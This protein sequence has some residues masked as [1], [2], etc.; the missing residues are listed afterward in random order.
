VAVGRDYIGPYRL[1][2]LI[3]A[4]KATQIW[5][6]MNPSD[7]ERVA[8]KSLQPSHLD[9]K[10]EL[11]VLRHEHTVGQNFSHPAVNRVR[12]FNV[13]RGIP[14]VVMDFF[15]APNLKQ[16]MR[17]F[18]ERIAQYRE[19]IIRQAA[20]ALQ[21]VHEKD[22]VHC[23]VKPDN[24]LLNEN[25]QLK[26]I[27]FAIAQKV[28]K[29]IGRLLSGKSAVQ[30]TRSYMAPEQIRGAS[31]DPRTDVYSLGCVLFELF[32]GKTPYTANNPDELLNKHLR[33][34]IPSLSAH[35]DDVTPE[36]A[37]L[38]SRM[39]AKK[40]EDRPQSMDAFLNELGKIS[41]TKRRPLA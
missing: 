27:D 16:S 9:N 29:G 14:Y 36:F 17:D 30:G 28:K 13:A 12:E 40:P 8:L 15:N 20:E 33:S 41:I 24:F 31:V 35:C 6:A 38:I 22:W 32:A 34:G 21:H 7:N 1:L 37:Q 2:K 25:G 18:P 23:D 10:A 19:Q 39:L 26:L 5:E 4:G 3:R 11:N